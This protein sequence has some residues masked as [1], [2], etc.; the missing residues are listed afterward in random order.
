MS[1][2][3]GL[4]CLDGGRVR[5]RNLQLRSTTS[6]QCLFAA[7]N[8]VIR[9]ES[10]VTFGASSAGC[11]H[12]WADI[13]GVIEILSGYTI[14]GGAGRHM[15]V[16]D[17]GRISHNGAYTVTLSGTP[18]FSQFALAIRQG[19]ILIANVTYSGGATGVRYTA[20]TGG[21]INTASGASPTYLPGNSAGSANGAAY[22]LYT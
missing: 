14:T 11:E 4:T 5:V 3:R 19:T 22:A 12:L 16:V 15:E 9:V 7:T 2:G 17:G 18:A 10:G 13:E 6:G 20:D 1:S 8:G 21:Q